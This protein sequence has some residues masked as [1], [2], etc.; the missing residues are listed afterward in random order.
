MGTTRTG[1]QGVDDQ[2]NVQPLSL[3]TCDP[4]AVGCVQVGITSID[5]FAAVVVY[6]YHLFVLI[7]MFLFHT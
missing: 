4:L 5:C 1:A 3:R 7:Q 2:L 6:K